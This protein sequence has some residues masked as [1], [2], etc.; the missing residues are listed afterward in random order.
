MKYLIEEAGAQLRPDGYGR[1]PSVIAAQCRV[2]DAVS[3]FV[4]ERE[5]VLDQPGD[6]ATDD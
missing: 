1:W 6:H 4:V 5:A 3:D 2:S